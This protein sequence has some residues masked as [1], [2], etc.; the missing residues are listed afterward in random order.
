MLMQGLLLDNESGN[1]IWV[2]SITIVVFI[3]ELMQVVCCEGHD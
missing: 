2:A 3:F 1:Q